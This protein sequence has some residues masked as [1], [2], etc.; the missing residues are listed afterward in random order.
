MTWTHWDQLALVYLHL[1]PGIGQQ[2]LRQIINWCRQN[3]ILPRSAWAK[4]D[5]LEPV[6]GSDLTVAVITHQASFSKSE[7]KSKLLAYHIKLLWDWDSQYPALLRQLSDPPV[8]LYCRGDLN[9]LNKPCIG[10]VGARQ[11]TRYGQRATYALVRD[12][13]R[14][15]FCIVSGF[16]YGVDA[17]AHQ[18]TLK[19][20]GQTIAVLG[21]GQFELF[22]S[23]QR[24]LLD[25]ILDKGGLIISEF[26]PDVKAKPGNFVHRN[27]IVA[28]LCQMIIVTEAA[29]RSGSH[30]TVQFG[31]DLGRS[32]GAVP[33]PF[34]NKFSQGTKW[35][36]NQG[37][38]MVTSGQD[39]LV[40][41]G[42]APEKPDLS[43]TVTQISSVRSLPEG[44]QAVVLDAL[45]KGETTLD[46]LAQTTQIE[47]GSLLSALCELELAGYVQNMGEYY[48]VLD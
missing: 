7:F 39:V 42:Q 14:E 41:L 28:A 43:T 31:L 20:S 29:A 44:I 17:C 3:Q 26:A 38:V 24:A 34:D 1:T 27:R 19:N 22:P 5:Q 10:V 37:A 36:I 4:P 23:H 13:V 32:V 46:Q 11:M 15:G 45:Q 30:I 18:A 9:L 6:I 2:Y 35:L 47:P 12:L 8:L 16:M 25:E 40:E 21:F 33:G 48:Q